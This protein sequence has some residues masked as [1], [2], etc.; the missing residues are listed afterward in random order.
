MSASSPQAALLGSRDYLKPTSFPQ[1]LVTGGIAVVLVVTLYTVFGAKQ[2]LDFGAAWAIG[3][4][5]LSLVISWKVTPRNF[6]VGFLTSLL[7][8]LI[9]WRIAAMA[10]GTDVI[11]AD[12]SASWVI[13]GSRPWALMWVCGIVTVFYLIQ[14]A[15]A[16]RNDLSHRTTGAWLVNLVWGA[17]LVRVWFGFNELGHATEKIFAG[18]ASW[19]HMT[20]Y[21]FGPLG[22]AAAGPF[23][24]LGNAPGFFVVL[25]GIIEISFGLGIGF[26][27]LTRFAG[28]LGVV[29]LVVATVWYGGEWTNGY[30]WAGGGWEYPMLLIVFLLSYVFTGAGPFSLDHALRAAGK[31]PVWLRPLSLTKSADDAYAAAGIPA[32]TTSGS[33][34]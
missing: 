30:G 2:I 3:L 14:F 12:G 5:A 28:V 25:A 27:L 18:S 17:T 22:E 33:A 23:G 19:S 8:V 11:A 1:S 7:P 16:W 29:Y 4:S 15:Q 6:T 20:N 9:V 31:L 24:L 13:T 34:A 26:G 10:G 21:V 32:A